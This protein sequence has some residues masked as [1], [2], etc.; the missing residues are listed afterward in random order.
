LLTHRERPLAGENEPPVLLSASPDPILVSL[1]LTDAADAGSP[2]A[3]QT[4]SVDVFDPNNPDDLTVYWYLD[5]SGNDQP[6][7]ACPVVGPTFPDQF[8]DIPG[9]DPDSRISSFPFS[10]DSEGC[11]KV[12]AVICDGAH[13]QN[14]DR[15]CA[16]RGCVDGVFEIPRAW[17]L[18]VHEGAV[19]TC[20]IEDC[21]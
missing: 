8:V 10:A 21:L 15:V 14:T 17:Y 18:C 6:P 16:Q 20:T 4:L 13:E 2:S 1:E 12:E 19:G 5:Y 11:H 9:A 7:P 3:S